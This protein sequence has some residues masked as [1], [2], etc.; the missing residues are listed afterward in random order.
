MSE[1]QSVSDHMQS[2]I[3]LWKSSGDRRAIFLSCYAMMT[4]NM[5]DAI[6]SSEFEDNQWVSTLLQRFAGY[7][8]NA[9]TAYDQ[10]PTN[11]P[12]VWQIAFNASRLP[13]THVLQNLGL[14]VNAHINYDLVFALSDMLAQEWPDL[15]PD[16]RKSRYRDH[17]H[18]NDV[19]AQTIDAVQDQVVERDDPAL[20]VAD[21][22]MGPLDEWFTARL[23][24]DWREKVWENATHLIQTQ[25]ESDRQLIL[26]EVEQRSL[27]R[28]RSILGE[29]GVAGLIDLL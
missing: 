12:A 19:I 29:L 16:Q 17:C 25:V 11:A 4:A 20:A 10:E 26:Q 24:T 2:L 1:T 22:L 21:K 27:E 18:V 3:D 8:F 5:L 6:A 13:R 9:L 28:A 15:T 14:G 23:I 7:Y